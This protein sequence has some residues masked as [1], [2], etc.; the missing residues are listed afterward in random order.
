MILLASDSGS[1]FG[2]ISLT[3]YFDARPREPRYCLAHVMFSGSLLIEPIVRLTRRILP[4]Q[5][6]AISS[7]G[8]LV[9]ELLGPLV[10]AIEAGP[11]G[12]DEG[13]RAGR[14][15]LGTGRFAAAPVA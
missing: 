12:V 6:I 14:A 9:A 3:R 4:A 5:D 15:G 7:S 11:I 8:L 1:T 10:H 2:S 13:D